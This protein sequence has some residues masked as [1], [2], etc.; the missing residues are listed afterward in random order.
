MSVIAIVQARTGSTRLAS[1]VLLELNGKPAIYWVMARVNRCPDVDKVILATSKL[2]RDDILADLAR[3]HGWNLFRGSE[4]DVLSRFVGIVDEERPSYVVRVCADNFA[5]DPGVISHG[6]NRL[7]QDSLDVCTPFIEN[8]YPFGAG[9]EVSTS[10]A[11][12][13]LDL[14]TK[15]LQDDFREH[16]YSYAYVN[17]KLFKIG[18]LQA[19]KNLARPEVN[20]SVDIQKQF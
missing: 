3:R 13:R 4:R 6:I 10:D 17:P 19:P 20:I 15:S 14:F 2:A 18:L 1:K 11:I 16:I 9:A 12:L 8:S 7:R 5:I